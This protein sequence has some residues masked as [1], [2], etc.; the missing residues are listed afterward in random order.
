MKFAMARVSSNITSMKILPSLL[1]AALLANSAA[2]SLNAAAGTFDEDAR[3][4]VKVLRGEIESHNRDLDARIQKLDDAIKNIGVIQLLNQIETLNAEIA[5]LRGQ[6][7]VMSNQND[8]LTKRQKD[9]YFDIDARLRKLEGTTDNNAPAGTNAAGQPNPVP[10]GPGLAGALPP[11]SG[12][13]TVNGNVVP[14]TVLPTPGPSAPVGGQP[15]RPTAPTYT[16][17]QENAA[18]DVGSNLFRRNDFSGAIRAFESFSRD[19]AGSSLVSNA[20]YWIGVSYFNLKDYNKA[21]ATQQELLKRFPE[22]AK[23]PDAMLSIATVQQETGDVRSAR[24]TLEDLIARY[25][26]SEAAA[27]GRTRLTQLRR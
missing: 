18:Y 1:L 17:E 7:E 27:K 4:E 9:F 15:P 2:F 10:S 25:P 20:Q 16:K 8:Q 24:N 13:G 6:I 3:R 14:A 11:P 23:A 26:G 12:V 21:K 22:S 19:F 5:R